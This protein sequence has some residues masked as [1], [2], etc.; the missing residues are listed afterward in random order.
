MT[1]N[2]LWLL[3]RYFIKFLNECKVNLV[4]LPNYAITAFL[5]FESKTFYHLLIK[6]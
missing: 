2:L 5:E 1:L 6:S 3:S 4:Y